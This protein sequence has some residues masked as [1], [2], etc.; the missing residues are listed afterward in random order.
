MAVAMTDDKENILFWV[1]TLAQWG[2]MLVMHYVKFKMFTIIGFFMIPMLILQF[3]T[4]CVFIFHA[5]K[6][7]VI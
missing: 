6:T 2:T 1:V 5:G 3:L 7:D 4:T